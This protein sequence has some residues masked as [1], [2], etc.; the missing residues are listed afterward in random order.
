M[1]VSVTVVMVSV[2][3]VAVEGDKAR[4]KAAGWLPT[5]TLPSPLLCYVTNSS[6][7]PSVSTSDVP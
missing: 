2:V 3:L 5:Y 7:R 1:L 4:R 6:L